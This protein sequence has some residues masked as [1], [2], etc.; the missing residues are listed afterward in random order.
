MEAHLSEMTDAAPFV[1]YG[2]LFSPDTQ[3]VTESLNHL[4]S[5]ENIDGTL[6]S[7]TADTLGHTR[8]RLSFKGLLLLFAGEAVRFRPGVSH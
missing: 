8:T 7:D 1:R 6:C 4:H 3:M 2:L 5:K